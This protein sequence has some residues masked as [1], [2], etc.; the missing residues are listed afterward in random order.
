MK[1]FMEL[2]FY[3]L[4]F[5]L[6]EYGNWVYDAGNNFIF[7]IESGPRERI[8]EA[9]NSEKGI[10]N[11]AQLSI[12]TEDPGMILNFGDPF[13]LIRGWGNLT[14]VGA[15]NFSAEKAAKI[16]DDLRDWIIWKLGLD[17]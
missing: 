1:T 10:S 4:P 13:I 17:E 5:R 2:N 8:V 12:D 7:Q 15:H 14:G 16:Q 9:L 3:K 6:A 11:K